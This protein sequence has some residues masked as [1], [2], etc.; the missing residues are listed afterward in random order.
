LTNTSISCECPH[1]F[2]GIKCELIDTL[3]L[4]VEKSR[5]RTVIYGFAIA[6]WVCLLSIGVYYIVQNDYLTRFFA[7][8]SRE[9]NS[10]LDRSREYLKSNFSFTKLNGEEDQGL[11]EPEM[12][13]L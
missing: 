6:L 3:P 4:A 8:H 7:S 1:G 9:N 11:T 10:I 2:S 12:I 5:L 13:Y